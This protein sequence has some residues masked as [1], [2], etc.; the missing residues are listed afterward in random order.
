MTWD[1]SPDDAVNGLTVSPNDAW[2]LVVGDFEKISGGRRDIGEFDVATG[3]LS[4]WR[5]SAPFSADAL[6][7][8]PDSSTV[9]VGGEGALEIFR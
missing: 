6:A 9:Y 5:P 3:L 7:F 4:A 8:R 1:P 2:L